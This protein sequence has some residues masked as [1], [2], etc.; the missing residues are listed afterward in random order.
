MTAGRQA[1]PARLLVEA[2][3]GSRGNPGPAGYGAVVKDAETGEVLA[4]V[5]ESLGTVTNNVAEYRGLIGG[6]GAASRIAPAADVDVRMDSKL[7]VEQMRGVWKVKHPDLRPLAAEAG[8][9]VRSFGSVTFSWVPR[10]RNGHADRLANEAMDGKPRTPAPA[11][12]V[13]VAEE[14]DHSAERART[15]VPLE[16]G[17]PTRTILVRHGQTAAA[18]AGWFNGAGGDEPLTD[19]GRTQAAAVADALFD[20]GAEAIVSSPL[21]RAKHTAEVMA[22][23]LGQPIREMA[24]LREAD[25]GEWEG[26]SWAQLKERYPKE[27]E[28]WL[29][30]PAVA[31]PGGESMV[32][33][34]RRAN[35]ARDKLIARYHDKTVLVVAHGMLL[36]ALVTVALGAPVASARRMRLENTAVSIVDWYADDYA[37]LI[38]LNDVTHLRT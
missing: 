24:E 15:F 16:L 30:D 5:A 21:I 23:R 3:G 27:V 33:V 38:S 1:A 7:V 11:A 29:S 20:S 13:G 10:A 14:P 26:L 22:E 36:S 12:P 4:E 6:L 37:R 25:F 17:T 18:Q 9:L 35:R 28:T 31:P 2:D 19:V 32:D 34:G 8:A